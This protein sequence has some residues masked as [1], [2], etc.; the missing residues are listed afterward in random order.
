MPDA[1][2]LQRLQSPNRVIEAEGTHRTTTGEGRVKLALKKTLHPTYRF[3]NRRRVCR[4]P[5][6]QLF[7]PRRSCFFPTLFI[8]GLN[9]PVTTRI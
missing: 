6:L 2:E 1:D 5:R 8:R 4:T 7:G 9:D 3:G